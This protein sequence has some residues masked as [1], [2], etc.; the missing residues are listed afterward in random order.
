MFR[1]FVSLMTNK[2]IHKT[3]VFSVFRVISPTLWPTYNRY[4][5]DLFPNG[6]PKTSLAVRWWGSCF[7]R[8]SFIPSESE[9]ALDKVVFV[10]GHKSGHY[11]V[12]TVR[13]EMGY[14]MQL[15]SSRKVIVMPS[16]HCRE[17]CSPMH[18]LMNE[19]DIMTYNPLVWRAVMMPNV[20]N[21]LS[22]GYL[23]SYSFAGLKQDEINPED[24]PPSSHDWEKKEWSI[25]LV[26]LFIE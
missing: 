14:Y 25:E 19:G 7:L 1:Y 8:P 2:I 17:V 18:T 23:G 9:V 24:Q 22:I 20:D 15:S 10:D 12:T 21:M 5:E 3:P 6:R 16:R 11:E 13:F 4:V 26:F